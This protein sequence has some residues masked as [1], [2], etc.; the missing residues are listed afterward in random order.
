MIRA[1]RMFGFKGLLPPQPPPAPPQVLPQVPEPARS[2]QEVGAVVPEHV[3]PLVAETL[4]PAPAVVKPKKLTWKERQKAAR[5]EQQERVDNLTV[6]D[7][8]RYEK[9]ALLAKKLT[10]PEFEPND[11]LKSFFKDVK[12]R[13]YFYNREVNQIGREIYNMYKPFYPKLTIDRSIR[14]VQEYLHKRNERSGNK[15]YIKE[16]QEKPVNPLGNTV[17]F[18]KH[19]QYGW[20]GIMGESVDQHQMSRIHDE[21]GHGYYANGNL[22]RY[23]VEHKKCF[24]SKKLVDA[25]AAIRAKKEAEEKQMRLKGIR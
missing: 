2:G 11:F 19:P 22:D 8:L 7:L 10:V 17:I 15:E 12:A 6:A 25:C 21:A 3:E 4:A 1:N 18:V 13:N 20:T 9:P 5:R 23:K 16:I 14:V 24:F